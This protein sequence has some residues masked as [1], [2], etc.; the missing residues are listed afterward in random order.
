MALNK[1]FFVPNSD[2]LILFDLTM[3]HAH[4]LAFR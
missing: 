3:C 2:I 1:P 4:E